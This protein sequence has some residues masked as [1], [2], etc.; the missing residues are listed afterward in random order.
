MHF[1]IIILSV[2]DKLKMYVPV[3]QEQL[4]VLTCNNVWMLGV[5][6]YSDSFRDVNNACW[7]LY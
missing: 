6:T 7:V 5:R 1:F 2:Y 3:F 4:V